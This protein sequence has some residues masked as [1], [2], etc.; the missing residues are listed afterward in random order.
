MFNVL[1]NMK[2]TKLSAKGVEISEIEV[3]DVKEESFGVYISGYYNGSWN[4]NILTI[5]VDRT[6]DVAINYITNVGISNT[7]AVVI[8][9]QIAQA[10]KKVVNLTFAG[11]VVHSIEP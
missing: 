8:A 9:K 5:F 6:I 7:G 11:K 4:S 3:V 10:T 1:E 2:S